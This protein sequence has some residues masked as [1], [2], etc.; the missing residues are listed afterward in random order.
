MRVSP[1]PYNRGGKK[2]RRVGQEVCVGFF[3][4][5]ERNRNMCTCFGQPL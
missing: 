4:G 5:G 3:L 1:G 2:Q